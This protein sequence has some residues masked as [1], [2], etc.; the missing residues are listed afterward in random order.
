MI[1][2]LF[3][4][5]IQFYI[6]QNT[7]LPGFI[8]RKERRKYPSLRSFTWSEDPE[9]SEGQLLVENTVQEWYDAKHATSSIF[10]IEFINSL[11]IKQCPFCESNDFTKYG[12]KKDG[13]QRYICK[14][15]GKRFTA[16]TN[17]IFDSKKFL[18]QNGLSIYCICLNFI[19]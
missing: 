4:Y 8:I 11:D 3:I 1:L 19:L 2:D 7:F 16:L 14:E 18:F 17:T 12:H 13:T 5:I 9:K 10:E 15:C 6:N